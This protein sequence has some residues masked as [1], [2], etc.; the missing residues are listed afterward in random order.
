[1]YLSINMDTIQFDIQEATQLNL[2]STD[3]LDTILGQEVCLLPKKQPKFHFL[4]FILKKDTMIIKFY[5]SL[6]KV[7]IKCQS[8]NKMMEKMKKKEQFLPDDILSGTQPGENCSLLCFNISEFMK[9][10]SNVRARN[11]IGIAKTLKGPEKANLSDFLIELGSHTIKITDITPEKKFYDRLTQD[12]D[13]I[14][15]LLDRG[16][17]IFYKKGVQD[18]EVLYLVELI[19]M[20]DEV[21]TKISG[22]RNPNVNRHLP[23]IFEFIEKIAYRYVIKAIEDSLIKTTII[24]ASSHI[25]RSI[26]MLFDKKIINIEIPEMNLGLFMMYFNQRLRK[27]FYEVRGELKPELSPKV[28]LV[29]HLPN[30][31]FDM[32]TLQ[33]LNQDYCYFYSSK[34][35]DRFGTRMFYM[36]HNL[37]ETNL[38]VSDEFKSRDGGYIFGVLD[39]KEVGDTIELSPAKFLVLQGDGSYKLS[40]DHLEEQLQTF[41]VREYEK[42]K[43]MVTFTVWCLANP[44]FV[45]LISTPF[46][47]MMK[48]SYLGYNIE[49]MFSLFLSTQLMMKRDIESLLE[50]NRQIFSHASETGNCS[51]ISLDNTLDKMFLHNRFLTLCES[52]E[53]TITSVV[54]RSNFKIIFFYRN[55]HQGFSI[56]KF[57]LQEF[58]EE[59]NEYFKKRSNLFDKVELDFYMLVVPKQLELEGFPSS[60]D[61]NDDIQNESVEELMEQVAV[62]RNFFGTTLEVQTKIKVPFRRFFLMLNINYQKIHLYN[63][64]IKQAVAKSIE[65]KVKNF[66]SIANTK[67]QLNTFV[68]LQKIG[69]PSKRNLINNKANRSMNITDFINNMIDDKTD[70]FT[71]SDFLLVEENREAFLS[72]IYKLQFSL[73]NNYQ[74]NGVELVNIPKSREMIGDM[75]GSLSRNYFKVVRAY[76]EKRNVEKNLRDFIWSP[77]AN[78]MR[79]DEFYKKVNSK[80]ILTVHFPFYLPQTVQSQLEDGPNKSAK[81]AGLFRSCQKDIVELK[82]A[83]ASKE[84]HLR[85]QAMFDTE[86]KLNP[87]L[88]SCVVD[89]FYSE[90]FKEELRKLITHTD[91]VTRIYLAMLSHIYFLEVTLE[92]CKITVNLFCFQSQKVTLAQV[93]VPTFSIDFGDV[94]NFDVYYEEV[95]KEKRSSSY[96]LLISHLFEYFHDN[97]IVKQSY[98]LINYYIETKDKALSEGS[99]EYFKY[100]LAPSENGIQNFFEIQAQGQRAWIFLVAMNERF[101]KLASS[102]SVCYQDPEE[103]NGRVSSGLAVSPNASKIFDVLMMLPDAKEFPAHPKN[104]TLDETIYR[105]YVLRFLM[106]RFIASYPSKINVLVEEVFMR[107]GRVDKFMDRINELG[108]FDESFFEYVRKNFKCHNFRNEQESYLIFFDSNIILV[109]EFRRNY[110]SK[111]FTNS[112]V[113]IDLEVFGP[114]YEIKPWIQKLFY[115]WC[116]NFCI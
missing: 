53:R 21:Q 111:I 19:K 93:Q 54:K 27:F 46:I 90:Y 36:S 81:I 63:Y 56:L 94:I 112:D 100:L 92:G 79:I 51:I 74:V 4:Y 113:L 108:I 5:Q 7:T 32:W 49:M 37:A 13:L 89:R 34:N 66:V 3:N 67:M 43:D 18:T 16:R 115:L 26:E 55:S 72:E 88:K 25:I 1:M 2:I 76:I 35:D 65:T 97:P 68:A 48:E 11:I 62:E 64:N 9:L 38:I 59:M 17:F 102:S 109:M 114:K 58:S 60:N 103:R 8:C 101:A 42:P 70:V 44:D 87:D 75:F 116:V 96:G 57:D 30:I 22:Y 40:F 69:I 78:E 80:P 33:K 23:Q 104:E 91:K 31:N 24:E 41:R 83:Q 20:N 110:L 12:Q 105:N 47:E 52:I 61:D 45:N 98:R 15:F 84:R 73:V 39:D 77:K 50:F 14:H 107:Y 106:E 99:L 6:Q 10:V 85:F 86:T 82:F 71:T 29:S 28:K 95:K